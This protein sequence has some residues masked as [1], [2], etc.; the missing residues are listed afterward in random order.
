MRNSSGLGRAQTRCMTATRD[1]GGYF[2][3]RGGCRWMGS[4]FQN[5]IDYH[6]V[7][8]SLELL[9]WGRKFSDFWGKTIL[10]IYG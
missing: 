1:P 3:I 10:H 7:A 5:W 2:L 8:F 6:G 4:H 9:E